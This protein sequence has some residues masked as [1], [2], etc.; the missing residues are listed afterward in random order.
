MAKLPDAASKRSG[1]LVFLLT[2]LA[3]QDTE[4]TAAIFFVYS[5]VNRTVISSRSSSSRAKALSGWEHPRATPKPTCICG[6]YYLLFHS[7][8]FVTTLSTKA[9]GGGPS[10]G[11]PHVSHQQP[12]PAI[13][14][15]QSMD[16][17]WMRKRCLKKPLCSNLRDTRL[18]LQK[19]AENAG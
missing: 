6:G 9:T 7:F 16:S 19:A 14:Q 5:L 13:A 18:S 17:C 1:R 8:R 12:W 10:A 11:R 3:V 2:S 4:I 15:L